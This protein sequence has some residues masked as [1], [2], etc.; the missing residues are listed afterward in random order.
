MGIRLRALRDANG[1]R[2]FEG[3]DV[4]DTL[5]RCAEERA[6]LDR[7]A[8]RHTPR[9]NAFCMTRCLGERS[10]GD[11]CLI[12]PMRGSRSTMPIHPNAVDAPSQRAGHAQTGAHCV[13]VRRRRGG[14]G[15]GFR[16]RYVLQDREAVPVQFHIYP[17]A[18]WGFYRRVFRNTEVMPLAVSP[19]G[20]ALCSSLQQPARRTR[21]VVK[22]VKRHECAGPA[23]NRTA[24]RRHSGRRT[25]GLS[26]S[27]PSAS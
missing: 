21:V 15:C 22:I 6:R 20:A 13:V 10:K 23:R 19:N 2:A 16:N 1:T 9:E 5:R 12:S 26:D 11:G 14:C 25:A 24:R 7:A 17:A 18:G 4:I 27:S 8:G 3:E